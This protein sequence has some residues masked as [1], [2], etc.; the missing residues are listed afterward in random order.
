MSYKAFRL[1]FVVPPA[2][3]LLSSLYWL[4][5]F[6]SFFHLEIHMIWHTIIF[7]RFACYKNDSFF[8]YLIVYILLGILLRELPCWYLKLY[9]LCFNISHGLIHWFSMYFCGN[10]FMEHLED[11]DNTFSLQRMQSFHFDNST[12]VL[13]S[14]KLFVFFS[15]RFQFR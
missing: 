2:R 13:L 5:P 7:Y 10:L 6:Y 15:K 12:C 1:S 9:I 8:K 11:K 14:W 4:S 3:E